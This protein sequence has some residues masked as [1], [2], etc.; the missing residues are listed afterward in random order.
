MKLLQETIRS[1]AP[2]NQQATCE[3]QE[4]LDSLLKPRGSL[5]K[6]EDIARQVAGITGKVQNRFHKKVVMVMAADNG[7]ATEGVTA[8]PQDITMWVADCM[9]RG[10]SGLGVLARHAG[11]DIRVVDLGIINDVPT[12]GIINRKIRRGT[13]NFLH[14]Q[15]MSRGEAIEAI[16]IGIEETLRAIDEG[17]DLVGTAE[18]GIGNTTTS[19]AVLHVLTGDGLDSVVGR[20]TGI[21][22]DALA[23]KKELIRLAV[24]KHRPDASDP[25]DILAKVGGFDIAALAGSFLASASRGVPVVVDGFI[26]GVAALLALRFNPLARDYMILSHGSAEPG[27]RIIERELGMEP[28]LFMDMRL[29]EGTG[30]TL[31]FNIIE[32]SMAIMNEQGTFA[33]IQFPA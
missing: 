17:Y 18:K 21:S 1:I 33:D 14:G 8:Y 27:A 11:A 6:L 22:D 29:G 28:L 23:R 32:A 20:G 24:E 30:C 10:I 5:G 15:A 2:V 12:P 9:L 7:I 31:A 13:S 19:A 25:V 4:R 3:A 26:S 16:E